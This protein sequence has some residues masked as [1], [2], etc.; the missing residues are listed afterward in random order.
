MFGEAIAVGSFIAAGQLADQLG[1]RRLRVGAL[2]FLRSARHLNWRR[3]VSQQA[4]RAYTKVYGNK[5]SSFQFQ[6]RS[7]LIYLIL[8]AGSLT[9]L[10]FFFP[11]QYQIVTSVFAYG[12]TW[13]VA[14]W[15]TAAVLGMFLYILA[16]AQTL[17]FLEILKSAPTF[18]R[19]VLVAYADILITSSVA[20]FGVP[21]LMLTTSVFATKGSQADVNI[22]FQFEQHVRSTSLDL[23]N[24][25]GSKISVEQQDQLIRS[26][27]E[28]FHLEVNFVVEPSDKVMYLRDFDLTKKYIQNGIIPNAEF[29]EKYNTLRVR[30]ESGSII[31]FRERDLGLKDSV[32]TV[33]FLENKDSVEDRRLRFCKDFSSNKSPDYPYVIYSMS[34]EQRFRLR[35]ACEERD[36]VSLT[37][38]VR[39]NT[40]NVDYGGTYRFF[41]GSNLTDLLRSLGSGFQT[42][43]AL[44]PYSM[45]SPT[46]NFG[47]WW[48]VHRIG[49]VENRT[50]VAMD[51]A[52]RSALFT[53]LGG[54]NAI[55]NNAFAAGT[56]NFAIMST[57]AFN[58]LVIGF[59]LLFYP[60]YLVLHNFGSIA[61]FTRLRKYPFTLLGLLTAAYFVLLSS[62]FR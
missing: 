40:D 26:R 28:M 54:Y 8:F 24:T 19:F 16:N 33:E 22:T 41:L 9:F 61:R 2:S 5:S 45:L 32:S 39:I 35:K 46:D 37:I 15:L 36:T 4:W 13:Q 10:Y 20:L 7:G 14:G 30:D 1:S 6:L 25:Y 52:L 55:L 51:Q 29:D 53:E 50:A 59:L 17:Y 48:H 18:F 38:P 12:N 49:E 3:F 62:L 47:G 44:S 42:Y 21:F 27:D 60:V 23:L 31:G 56:V 11:H 58:L 34:G 43:L 57:A